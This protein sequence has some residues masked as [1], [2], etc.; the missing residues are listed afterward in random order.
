MGELGGQGGQ[1]RPTLFILLRN[2][3][4]GGPSTLPAPIGLVRSVVTDRVGKVTEDKV[5]GDLS[6]PD[7]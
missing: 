2:L 6:S 5:L 4:V 3:H 1:N 7:I